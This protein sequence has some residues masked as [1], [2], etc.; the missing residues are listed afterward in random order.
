MTHGAA[1]SPGSAGR[2]LLGRQKRVDPCER[3]RGRAI[4]SIDFGAGQLRFDLQLCRLLCDLGQ[5]KEPLCASLP[6]SVSGSFNHKIYLRASF[7]ASGAWN[8]TQ[9]VVGWVALLLDLGGEGGPPGAT[10]P[11]Q[12]TAATRLTPEPWITSCVLPDFRRPV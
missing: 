3:R 2:A 8:G 4:G 7:Q 9:H 5:V 11:G 6:S 12:A 1:V 10:D